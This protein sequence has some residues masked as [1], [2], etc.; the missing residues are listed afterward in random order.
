MLLTELDRELLNGKAGPGTAL[1]MSVVTQMAKAMGA[2]R[3]LDIS[4]AHID[5]CLYHGRAGLDFA[6]R[7]VEGGARTAVPATLNVAAL[8]L[9]HPDLY[10]G[11]P[12]TAREARRLMDAYLSLGCVPSW[13]CAPY[14]LPGRPHRGQQIAWAESNAIVFAN[15]VLGA[16]T[17]RYGDFLDIS[18]AVTGR[19]PAVGLHLDGGRTATWV[20]V[21]RGLDEWLDADWLYPVLGYELG[22]IDPVGIPALIGLDTR[23]TEDRLKA[24]GAGAASTG[25]IAMFH[26]VGVTPEA[27]TLDEA[28]GGRRLPRVVIDRDRILAARQRLSRGAK[29]PVSAVSLGAP[30]YSAAELT[31]LSGWLQGRQVNLPLFVNTNRQAMTAAAAE[32]SILERA[33]ATIVTDTCTYI[34]PILDPGIKVVM[35][36]SAKWAY[37]A[38]GNLGVGV[39]FGSPEECVAVALRES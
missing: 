28:S 13:T 37:Y 3:L 17:E 23:A 35:T 32:V 22:L 18:C 7:L 25:A 12:D 36:D 19:A 15:S 30:H 4:A 2:G 20:A 9:L 33:G 34:T 21:L 5:G 38:P 10:R 14:Q 11:D 1:A 8:D 39:V 24:L 29:G 31:R 27:G 16:R 6:L 26:A